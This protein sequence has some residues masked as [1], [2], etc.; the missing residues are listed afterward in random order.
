MLVV[1]L[2]AVHVFDFLFEAGVRRLEST[3]EIVP[4]ILFLLRRINK[5]GVPL[6][7]SVVPFKWSLARGLYPSPKLCTKKLK[8]P[9]PIS[10]YTTKYIRSIHFWSEPSRHDIVWKCCESKSSKL[11]IYQIYLG[12]FYFISSFIF[13]PIKARTYDT[14]YPIKALHDDTR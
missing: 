5:S 1:N 13:L 7:C 8:K 6:C 9:R 3:Q 10:F 12:F 11:S 14:S 4:L 2:S